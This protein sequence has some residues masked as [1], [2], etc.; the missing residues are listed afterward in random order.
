MLPKMYYCIAG[1][2]VNL[3]VLWPS[4]VEERKSVYNNVSAIS[5]Y[6]YPDIDHMSSEFIACNLCKTWSSIEN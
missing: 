1:D 4:Q 6:T 5:S 2:P 3:A